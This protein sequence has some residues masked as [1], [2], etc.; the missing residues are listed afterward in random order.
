MSTPLQKRT[1]NIDFEDISPC[2]IPNDYFASVVLNVIHIIIPSGELWFCKMINLA[3]PH[4]TDRN[5]LLDAKGLIAQEGA[6]AKC[7][8]DVLTVFEQQGCDISF[9]KNRLDVA[10]D[11]HLGEKIYGRWTVP[12]NRE[13]WWLMVRL[14]IMANMEHVTCVLGNWILQNQALER[15][16]ADIRMLN[17]LKWHGAEEVEH[18]NVAHDVYR[19]L[20]GGNLLRIAMFIPVLFYIVLAWRR[21]TKALSTEQK[22]QSSKKGIRGYIES[23]RRGHLPSIS[24]LIFNFL[25]YIKWNFHPENEGDIVR[26]A[27]EIER[28]DSLFDENDTAVDKP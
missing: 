10:F 22:G 13:R 4:I 23:S 7:H 28:L 26:A 27:T 8:R 24:Y 18:R 3:K 20:G 12:E 1:P 16:N 5:L 21:G 19:H 9:S 11:Q 17:L 2:W 14:G 6:H 25:K 15:D